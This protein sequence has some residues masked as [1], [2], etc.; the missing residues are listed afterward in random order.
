MTMAQARKIARNLI[1]GADGWTSS[2]YTTSIDTSGFMILD[3]CTAQ[4]N[5]GRIDEFA[6]E[7]AARAVQEYANGAKED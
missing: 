6:N 2:D 7:V 3:G 4:I 5:W 1:G